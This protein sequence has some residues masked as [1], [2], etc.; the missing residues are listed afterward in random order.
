M[1]GFRVL[2]S[3]SVHDFSVFLRLR[4]TRR[5]RFDVRYYYDHLDRLAT[6][7]DNY[8]NVTHF[9]Y[10][11][12]Q[13]PNEVCP[14]IRTSEGST[15]GILLMPELYSVLC[16]LCT[17]CVCVCVCVCVTMCACD[18]FCVHVCVY[19]YKSFIYL[20]SNP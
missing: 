16:T 7:K 1:T 17:K 5:G 11:N 13:R 10:T 14:Q 4:A 19:P 15:F 18:C 3:C 8:E 20:A 6:R 2:K 12:H 9:F